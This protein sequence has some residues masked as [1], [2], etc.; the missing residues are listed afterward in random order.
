MRLLVFAVALYGVYI[1]ARGLLAL[2]LDTKALPAILTATA[3]AFV[4]LYL[5][6]SLL[7]AFAAHLVLFVIGRT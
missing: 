2:G 6:I 4:T 5:P 3:V 7:L 1:L